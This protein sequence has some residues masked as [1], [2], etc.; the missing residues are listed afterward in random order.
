MEK[1][2]VVALKAEKALEFIVVTDQVG[3]CHTNTLT[4]FGDDPVCITSHFKLLII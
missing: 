2:T 4:L 1:R 3:V